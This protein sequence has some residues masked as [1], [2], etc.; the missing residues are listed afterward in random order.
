MNENKRNMKQNK[1]LTNWNISLLLS[2]LTWRHRPITSQLMRMAGNLSTVHVRRHLVFSD[3]TLHDRLQSTGLLE[4]LILPRKPQIR[5]LSTVCLTVLIH[6]DG[7]DQNPGTDTGFSALLVCVSFQWDKIIVT[8]NQLLLDIRV[9]AGLNGFPAPRVQLSVLTSFRDILCFCFPGSVSG[10]IVWILVNQ[11]QLI[12][13]LWADAIKTF[14]LTLDED[15][16]NHRWQLAE[17]Y[18]LLM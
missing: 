18:S 3:V 15:W 9:G 4:T 8:Q 7:P 5:S 13:F 14:N 11:N 10:R 1:N 2:H 16:L 17:V 6:H 12:W